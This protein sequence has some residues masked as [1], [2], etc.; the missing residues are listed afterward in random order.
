M[1]VAKNVSSSVM[2]YDVTVVDKCLPF[3]R[4][5][6]WSVLQEK[7]LQTLLKMIQH[8]AKITNSF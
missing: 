6:M 7:R 5:V 8:M 2:L 4:L 1:T 3:F